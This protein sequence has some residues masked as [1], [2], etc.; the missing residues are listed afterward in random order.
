M[1][2]LILNPILYTAETDRIPRVS[3]IKDTMIY[4]LCIGFVK[5]GDEPTLIAAE[6]Y[7]PDQE[8]EYPFRIIWMSCSLPAV[9]KP[10]CFPLLKGLGRYLRKH[11]HE[12]D[13]VVSSEV[14]SMLT[15]SGSL[16]A[17]KKMIIWH[18]LGAHNN[19]MRKVPSL[20]WYNIVARIMMRNIPIIPRSDRAAE[21]IGKYC[22]NV[23]SMRIDHGV[24]LEKIN[25]SRQKGNYFVVLSQ[26]IERKHIDQIID[27]FAAFYH[28]EEGKSFQL[29]II[30]DGVMREALE[31]QVEGLGLEASVQFLGRQTHEIL[32][33]VLSM[34][35]ALLVNTSKDNSMVSIVESIAAGTP[36]ITTSVPFNSVYI[37]NEKLGIVKDKWGYKEL[38]EVSAKNS[39]YVENCIKYR[40]RLSNEYLAAQFDLIG[41]TL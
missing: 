38:M 37:K 7:R 9:W 31:R 15:L 27:H 23:L 36:V 2:I 25:C 20:F 12:Y 5:N 34:A 6:N 32:M 26:L 19:L 1:K 41:R 3:S 14:F 39:E 35:K 29:K 28:T 11:Q 13:Y 40:K 10:R 24:D 21:F 16:W 8:E 4:S 30:G 22:N 17:R 18:E 33:P